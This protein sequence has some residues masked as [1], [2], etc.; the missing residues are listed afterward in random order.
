MN[1][2]HC[3]MGAAF[4][5]VAGA[6]GVF[7]A[8]ISYDVDAMVDTPLAL[9]EDTEISVAEG[10]TVTYTAA[11]SGD[12][13]LTKT[14]AGELVLAAVNSFGSARIEAGVLRA[15]CNGALGSGTITIVGSTTATCRLDFGV[16]PAAATFANAFVL[17]SASSSTYPAVRFWTDGKNSAN[18]TIS[19]AGSWTVNADI[20]FSEMCNSSP[21]GIV[22]YTFNCPFDAGAN[23]IQFGAASAIAW[24]GEVTARQFYAPG[25]A[26][27]S[28]SDFVDNYLR[29][30][31]HFYATN[32]VGELKV[33]YNGASIHTKDA[34]DG[35]LNLCSRSGSSSATRGNAVFHADNTLAAF[36]SPNATEDTDNMR[37]N[38]DNTTAVELTITG[39][40]ATATQTCS[41]KM[42]GAVSLTLDAYDDFKQVIQKRIH[43]TTGCLTVKKGTLSLEGPTTFA[44]VQAVSVRGGTLDCL[45]TLADCF[46]TATNLF[47]GASGTL[48]F[49]ATAVTPVRDDSAMDFE[50]ETGSTIS[51]AEPVTWHVRR[52]VVDGKCRGIDTWTSANCAALPANLTVVS[53]V[54]DAEE[55][56]DIGWK[57]GADDFTAPENWG[58]TGESLD[59]SGNKY[60]ATFAADDAVTREAAV[61]GPVSLH[62]IVFAGQNFGLHAADDSAVLS[63]FE[64]QIAFDDDSDANAEAHAYTNDVPTAF[65]GDAAIDVPVLDTLTLGDITTTYGLDFTGKG[66]TYLNG[67]IQADGVMKFRNGRTYLRGTIAAVDH[68]TQAYASDC[69]LR[70]DY[71]GTAMSSLKYSLVLD[72][73]VIEKPIYATANA[74]ATAVLA[75]AANSTNLITGEVRTSSPMA[76][77][78]VGAGS[79][80]TL[81]GGA[82]FGWTIRNTGAGTLV[83]TNKPFSNHSSAGT[84]AYNGVLRLEV[85][86]NN[87]GEIMGVHGGRLET[88]VD[89]AFSC[90]AMKLNTGTA[91][92]KDTCQSVPRVITENRNTVLTGEYGSCLRI[93][94]GPAAPIGGTNVSFQVTGGMSLAM[95][96]TGVLLLTNQTFA[97]CGD[98]AVT[99]GVLE[100]AADASWLNGT[101]FT[102][103]G[104]GTL[105]FGAANQVDRRFARLHVADTGK[106]E[107]PADVTLKVASADVDGEPV[108]PGVY[109][110]G[111][112][113][114][115]AYVEGEGAVQVGPSGVLLLVR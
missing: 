79:L 94:K 80:L 33:K 52:F 90:T 89:N 15:N 39:T 93:S 8:T 18:K 32:H 105:R 87:A 63:L 101:N 57:G 24:K 65:F 26:G 50:I 81:S 62:G 10:V 14:G 68:V 30:A 34:L 113:G 82:A 36:V 53:S 46:A 86:G 88:T 21:Q 100:L 59:F 104:T 16:M 109:R 96:G 103:K 70:L 44:S 13:K 102:A 98:L 1:M 107:I 64:A 6:F 114:F 108:A 73:G 47:V 78:T 75:T 69:Y 27:G 54:T 31:H 22:Y 67:D 66:T 9:A 5:A 84:Y 71:S 4:V 25:N 92:F 19:F 41:I 2:N 61:S 23:L 76:A 99:N 42:M 91:D 112:D 72:N 95:G 111:D 97:S 115:G 74:S 110:K 35:V 7:G 77:I 48:N 106:V 28:H 38:Y 40:P 43:T 51:L 56:E 29:G 85:A 11:I 37:L 12:Y 55:V 83:I 20:Y 49:A 17:E 3:L 58:R 60:V 45:T